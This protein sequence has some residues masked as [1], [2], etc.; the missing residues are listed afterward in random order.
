MKIGAQT[1]IFFQIIKSV[2][3]LVNLIQRRSQTRLNRTH[4]HGRPTE[5]FYYDYKRKPLN[6]KTRKGWCYQKI[7]C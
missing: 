2:G 6:V 3:H 1:Q 4:V 5:K 7:V